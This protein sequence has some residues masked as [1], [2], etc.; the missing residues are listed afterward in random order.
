M[1][2]SIFT[3]EFKQ[4]IVKYILNHPDK[5]KVAVAKTF[6]IVNNNSP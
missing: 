2:K 4:R 1:I 5:S 6:S 3:D